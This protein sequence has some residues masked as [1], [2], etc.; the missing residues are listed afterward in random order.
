MSVIRGESIDW[1]STRKY[2]H[3]LART[4]LGRRFQGKVDV[5]DV[6]QQTLLQALQHSNQFKGRSERER[7]SWLRTILSNHVT[8]RARHY[9]Q[10]CRDVGLERSIDDDF[11]HR[12]QQL[13]R[14]LALH[15]ST[16]SQKL[17]HEERLVWLACELDNL[18][19][20]QRDAMECYYIR[21]LSFAETAHELGRTKPAVAGLIYRAVQSLRERMQRDWQLDEV[22]RNEK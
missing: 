16:P 18:P 6:V 1:E 21:Q 12:S 11:S 17:D 15:E 22:Q 19:S 4:L 5:S 20:D 10:K 7:L 2:L 3:F 9:A 14:W 13:D 8:E